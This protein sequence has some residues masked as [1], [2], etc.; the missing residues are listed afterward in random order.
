MC[1]F[2]MHHLILCIKTFSRNIGK[3]T[4]QIKKKKNETTKK[5]WKTP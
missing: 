3:C 5:T 2:G 1:E 4:S